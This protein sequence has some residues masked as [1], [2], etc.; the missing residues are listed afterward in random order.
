MVT[1]NVSVGWR[2][3]NG[4][5]FGRLEGYFRLEMKYICKHKDFILIL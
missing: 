3:V 1:I 5:D 4:C 2:S